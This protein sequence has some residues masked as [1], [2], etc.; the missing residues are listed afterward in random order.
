MEIPYLRV[1]E[2][3]Y[4][5]FPLRKGFLFRK[6]ASCAFLV[7]SVENDAGVQQYVTLV[8][9]ILL[10]ITGFLCYLVVIATLRAE[11]APSGW[12]DPKARS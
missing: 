9:Q 3:G 5:L 8:A 11:D 4:P 1:G 10:S 2:G 7:C 6:D 12:F